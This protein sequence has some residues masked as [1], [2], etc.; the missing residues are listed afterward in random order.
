M[1]SLYLCHFIYQA[2]HTKWTK[3]NVE[4]YTY[5]KVVDILH[6][7]YK[8]LNAKLI[9]KNILQSSVESKYGSKTKHCTATVSRENACKGVD[10]LE[11]N[12]SD[13]K[14]EDV[15]DKDSEIETLEEPYLLKIK[16]IRNIKIVIAYIVSV[17]IVSVKVFK[18][19]DN[20]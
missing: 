16:W 3:I 18:T 17:L 9:D 14:I 11:A 8:V 2:G 10:N 4:I 13:P 20:I 19:G 15:I 7:K 12:M 6:K 1:F 5:D